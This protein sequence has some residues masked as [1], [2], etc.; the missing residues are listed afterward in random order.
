MLFG[1]YIS[2]QKKIDQIFE[3]ERV[4]RWEKEDYKKQTHLR[5]EKE[6]NAL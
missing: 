2:Q 4:G 5:V 1:N 3:K 6:E